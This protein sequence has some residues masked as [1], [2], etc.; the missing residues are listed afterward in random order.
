ME[1][2]QLPILPPDKVTKE[3]VQAMFNKYLGAQNY[4]KTLA[5]AQSLTFTKDNL[6]ADYPA[7]KQLD[8][9]LKGLESV[10]KQWKSAYDA[11]GNIIQE[12]FKE[13]S[14]PLEAIQQ[15][16]KTELKTANEQALAEKRQAEQE[17][18]RKDGIL[19]A[20]GAFINQVA[21]N[22]STASTDEE[23]TRIQKLIGS[24]KAR[25]GFYQEYHSELVEKCNGLDASIKERKSFIKQKTENEAKLKQAMDAGNLDEAAVLKAKQDI[26][27]TK[28]DE[29][30]IILQ[31]EAFKQ[32]LDISTV[33]GEPI[34]D[35]VKPR[36]VKWKWKLEDINLLYKKMP[37]LVKLVPDEEAI[38][39]ILNTKKAEKQLPDGE[40]VKFFGITFY[41]EKYY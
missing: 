26:L 40:E 32:N 30:S 34:I 36:M 7:L 28:A 9:L 41:Q 13:I 8:G 18:A 35:T 3:I 14:K 37:H 22:V 15:Q 38:D 19:K 11:P 10:R 24:E 1:E 25:T 23:I 21:L 33:V 27:T 17:Q 29:S 4:A 31:E 2:N 6:S 16:K 20:I 39:A 12:V 5:A